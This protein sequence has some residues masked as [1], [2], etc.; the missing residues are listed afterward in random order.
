MN[1]PT[2]LTDQLTLHAPTTMTAS[3]APVAKEDA[4]LQA[5]VH[6]QLL[7]VLCLEQELREKNAH[8]AVLTEER[9][10]MRST[11]ET[12]LAE[13]T[14]AL[15]VEQARVQALTA[16]T[17]ELR[18]QALAKQLNAS[19]ALKAPSV[20]DSINEKLALLHNRQ[21][22]A[23]ASSASR[24]LLQRAA[25]TPVMHEDADE[26]PISEEAAASGSCVGEDLH[27]VKHELALATEQVVQL[28]FALQQAREAAEGQLLA[29]DA[30]LAELRLQARERPNV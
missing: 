20:A 12:R 23:H 8:V 27:A 28:T 21:R 10:R 15:A 3:T 4:A 1:C 2:V 14:Q 11:W 18:T 29:K 17:I 24:T 5:D 22:R 26:S 25:T 9:D 13:Q 7:R 19:H 30:E 6:A 16:S